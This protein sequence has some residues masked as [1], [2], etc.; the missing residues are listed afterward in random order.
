MPRFNA[1]ITLRVNDQDVTVNS[2]LPAERSLLEALR[3]D[4][5]LTGTKYGCGE[6]QCGA[7]TVLI[8]GKPAFS[9]VTTLAQAQGKS[10]TTIEG[11]AKGEVLHPAQRAFAD[12][13][14]F[15]CGYCSSGMIIAAA[16]LLS[17]TT[18]PSDDEIVE[19]MDG[20][21]CRCCGYARIKQAVKDAAGLART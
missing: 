16:A 9:C 7:C 3:E 1:V 10:I 5:H 19:A 18:T 14:A 2:D 17:R 8:D 21:I 6:A 15:Q 11:L 12:A 13:E 4:L 20:H